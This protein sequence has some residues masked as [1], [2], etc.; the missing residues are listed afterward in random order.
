LHGVLL[1]TRQKRGTA[2]TFILPLIRSL[3]FRLLVSLH[4]RWSP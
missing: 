2:F 3:S 4:P 1:Q